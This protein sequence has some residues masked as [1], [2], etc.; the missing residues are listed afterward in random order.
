MKAFQR[1]GVASCYFLEL[2]CGVFGSRFFLG[3][4]KAGKVVVIIRP[5]LSEAMNLRPFTHAFR[6]T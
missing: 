1:A 4:C 6:F 3:G 2:I 5:L